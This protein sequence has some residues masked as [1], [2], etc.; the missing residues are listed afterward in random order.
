[1]KVR[2]KS[3]PSSVFSSSEFN[4]HALGEVIGCGKDF[5]CDL[6]YIK[7][8]DVFIEA[9]THAGNHIGWKDMREAFKDKDLII[10]NYNTCFFEPK[11]EEDRQRGYTLN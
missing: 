11:N 7:D 1:M 5:G 8:L 6:F 2:M 10:D 4:T 3:N 9:R